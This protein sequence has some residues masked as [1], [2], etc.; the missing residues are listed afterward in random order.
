MFASVAEKP[1]RSHRLCR[2]WADCGLRLHAEETDTEVESRQLTEV[3]CAAIN[4]M[5][6][7]Y[8]MHLLEN[9][10]LVF[11]SNTPYAEFLEKLK[12]RVDF[13]TPADI[14]EMRAA[15]VVFMVRI[16]R[17]AC[18]LRILRRACGFGAWRSTV[19]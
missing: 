18:G 1:H 3:D 19:L 6:N 12:P 15:R 10:V 13:L 11:C 2:A 17:R 7:L 5:K 9:F 14:A 16:L 4:F 8:G